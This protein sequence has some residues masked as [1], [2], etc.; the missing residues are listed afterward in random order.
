MVKD[1]QNKINDYLVVLSSGRFQLNFI[2]SGD[3]M[4]IAIVDDGSTVSITALSTGELSRVNVATLL[5]IRNL[6]SSISNTKIN[7]LFLDEVLGVLDEP[8][9]ASL[10]DILLQE[11]DLNTFLV[12]HEY[13]HPLLEKIYIK[14]GHL[15]D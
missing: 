3:S 4:N 13:T 10:I 12:S 6:M 1:L 8:G 2:L 5:A 7:L 11:K 9:K 15:V 14:G